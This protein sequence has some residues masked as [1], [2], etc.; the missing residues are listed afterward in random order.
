LALAEARHR[1]GP[2][3]SAGPEPELA[4]IHVQRVL[5][6]APIGHS[7]VSPTRGVALQDLKHVDVD[8]DA[9]LAHLVTEA[10][11]VAGEPG[12]R[13]EVPTPGRWHRIGLSGG[14]DRG[15]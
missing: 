5:G 13:P 15:A 6:R 14:G 8:H 1:V 9:L 2:E 12:P 10:E 11:P 4:R 3:E 7:R